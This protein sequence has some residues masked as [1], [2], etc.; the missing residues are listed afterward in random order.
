MSVQPTHAFE[1]MSGQANLY[2]RVAQE[3]ATLVIREYS[4]SFS[5]ATRLLGS[6]VR[7]DVENI[8]GLVRLADEVV[9]GVAAAAGLSQKDVRR[10]LDDLERETESAMACGYS[11]NLI[12]HAFALTSRRCDIGTDLTRP[13]FASMRADVTEATHDPD[14]FSTYVYG[15]AEVVGLMCLQAFLRGKTVSTTDKETFVR[16]ARALGSAFQKVN[17]LRDL[18][19]DFDSLGRSYFPGVNLEHLTDEDKMRLVEDIDG[20]LELSARIIPMLPKSSRAAVM[21]AQSLF[22]ELNRRI[23]R[24]PAAVLRSTRVSVP[25]SRKAWLTA[26][27]LSGRT[28]S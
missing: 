27:A 13:F 25:N 9:D 26:R 21:L 5:M 20:E 11:T 19:A 15:S 3:S 10:R 4:T 28:P 1:R 16:G 12:V 23:A 8:Y 6:D 22:A 7:Q 18:S 2:D 17:F 14:S 24:T